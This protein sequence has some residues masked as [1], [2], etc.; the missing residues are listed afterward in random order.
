MP[1]IQINGTSIHYD[2]QGDGEP[3]I[4]IPF[5]TADHACFAFQLPAYAERFSCFTVDLRGSGATERGSRECTM[6]QFVEDVAAFITAMGC[7]KA[8][9]LGYSLGGA[10][11]MSF[12]AKYPDRLLSLGLHSTWP[13]SD[14]YLQTVV[15]SWQLVARALDDVCQTAIQAIFPWCFT[16]QRYA[17]QPEFIETVV[18]FALS[19]PRQRVGDFLEHS[20]AAIGH[21][22][23]DALRAIRAPTQVTFGTEDVITST[24][25]ARPMLDAIA[26]SELE[27]FEGSSHASFFEDVEGFNARTLAF[28]TRASAA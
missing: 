15:R 13:R 21:D 1:E 7:A 9:I 22:A 18:N 17:E 14:P 16:P 5:L 26:N 20:T 2:R 28:L 19:R 11:A 6:D 10:V 8:H 12:A 3:L 24:R 23:L 27:I 25:F 4:M